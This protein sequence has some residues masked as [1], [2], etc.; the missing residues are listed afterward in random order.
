MGF[1]S[2]GSSQ[3]LQGLGGGSKNQPLTPYREMDLI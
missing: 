2:L 3:S 1:P